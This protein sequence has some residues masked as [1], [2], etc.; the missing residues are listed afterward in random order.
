MSGRP[1]RAAAASSR[2][3]APADVVDFED[4]DLEF[5]ALSLKQRRAIDKAFEKGVRTIRGGEKRK[6]RKLANGKAMDVSGAEDGGGIVDESSRGGLMEAD[7]GGRPLSED[8]GGGFVVEDDGGGFVI[9]DDAG[10]FVPDNDQGGFLSEDDAGGFVADDGYQDRV[11]SENSKNPKQ[12]SHCHC[13]PQTSNKLVPLYLLPTLL[14]SLGLPSDEDVLEVFR[15]SAMGWD[16][17][18][19]KRG[20]DTEDTA[21]V[22]LKD[23]RAVCAALMDPDD[24]EEGKDVELGSDDDDDNDNE[25]AFQ[26]SGTESALTSL[27]E[28]SYGGTPSKSRSKT[29]GNKSRKTRVKGK[30]KIEG[31]TNLSS[32]QRAMVKDIWEMLKP[33]EKQKRFGADILGRNEV[34]ELVRT[35]GEMWSDEEITDMVTLFSSQHEG[36]GLTFE[37]FGRVMLRAGLV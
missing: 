15:A 2:H 5:L 31:Q 23:F 19:N 1:R 36:R 37:D 9:D 21:G 28:S 34:K 8:H 33:S 17:S 18:S 12:H 32:N 25:D 20:L 35:L 26:P 14:T 27:S 30:G 24:G 3:L 11:A 29:A 22:E 6:R 16:E 13:S 10:G 4:A 7:G